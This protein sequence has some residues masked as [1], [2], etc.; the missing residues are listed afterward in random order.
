MTRAL[1]NYLVCTHPRSGSNYFCQLLNST[2]RLGHPAEYFHAGH[3]KSLGMSADDARDMRRQ[4]DHFHGSMATPN[5]V[6]A[7]KM[8]WFDFQRLA[9][10]GLANV[11]K[12]YEFVFLERRD[13]LGQA[14]SIRKAR[15]TGKLTSEMHL[16]SVAVDFDFEDIRLRLLRLI[17]AENSWRAF[18]QE[19]AIRPVHCVYEVLVGNPQ[20]AVDSVAQAVGLRDVASVDAARI[21]LRIQRD[22]SSAAWRERFMDLAREADPVLWRYCRNLP[23]RELTIPA[24]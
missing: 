17:R 16:P 14:I 22:A 1:G 7:A 11:F 13:K 24:G 19:N 21:T 8:F 18:F 15:L 2:G 6:L 23:A 3:L 5:G 20:A 4:M 10:M 12:D 9:K